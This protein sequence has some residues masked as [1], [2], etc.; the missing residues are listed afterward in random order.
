MTIRHT[1]F[2]I[3]AVCASL[4]SCTGGSRPVPVPRPRAYPRIELSAPDYSPLTLGPVS[5]SVN[6]AATVA[7]DSSRMWLDL[8]Y[9]PAYGVTLNLTVTPVTRATLPDVLAN[10]TERMALNIGSSQAEVL[11]MRTR[12]GAAATLISSPAATLTPLQL[13][14]T[15]SATY[16]LSATISPRSSLPSRTDSVAPVHAALR[17]D[18]IRLLQSL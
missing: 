11:S 15:D 13:L 14:A 9:P 5:F 3:A 2:I 10:R 8:T 12:T 1:I 16:V 4:V 6:S 18:M 7:I 17:A